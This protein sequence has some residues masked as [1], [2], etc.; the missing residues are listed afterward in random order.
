MSPVNLYAFLQVAK[1]S[2]DVVLVTNCDRS[3][4]CKA[5]LEKF[6]SEIEHFGISLKC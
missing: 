2:E 5:K 4:K 6:K 3:P 1:Q